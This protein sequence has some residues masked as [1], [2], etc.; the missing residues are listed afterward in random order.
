MFSPPSSR[1][2]AITSRKAPST[3]APT[4]V[5]FTRLATNAYGY[6]F[7]RLVAAGQEGMDHGIGTLFQQGLGIAQR[8]L[9]LALGIE[10]D[11]I[12]ADGEDAGQLVGHDHHGG[13]E[14]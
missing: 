6:A 14:I 3:K 8:D 1:I 12:V 11:R 5:G 9:G 13:A 10:E 4:R 7:D 2:A